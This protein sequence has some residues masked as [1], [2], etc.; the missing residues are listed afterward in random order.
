MLIKWFNENDEYIIAETSIIEKAIQT[1]FRLQ[2]D[3]C[4]ILAIW[5]SS[6]KAQTFIYQ[7]VMIAYLEC[8]GII[9]YTAAPRNILCN[10]THAYIIII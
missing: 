2:I 1:L 5:K 8:V 10:T 4:F 6:Y 3:M 9:R 7:S